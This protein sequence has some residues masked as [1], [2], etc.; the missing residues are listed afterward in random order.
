MVN[1]EK[2]VL[3]VQRS[4]HGEENEVLVTEIGSA[5]DFY[6]LCGNSGGLSSNNY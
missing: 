6:V 3:Q 5:D 1:I 4:L 2:N